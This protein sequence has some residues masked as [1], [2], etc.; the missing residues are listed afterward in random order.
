MMDL[1]PEEY[2]LNVKSCV[3]LCCI[4]NNNAHGFLDE[5]ESFQNGRKKNQF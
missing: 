2:K 4:L 1:T 5:T 3:T